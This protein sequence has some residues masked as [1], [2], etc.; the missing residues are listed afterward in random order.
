MSGWIAVDLDGTLAEYHGWV[1]EEHIGAP[2]APMVERVKEWL[3]AGREVRVFTARV[4]GEE[5]QRIKSFI[6]AWCLEYVGVILPVTNKKDYGMIELWDDRCIQVIPNKGLPLGDTGRFPEGHLNEHDE[7]E[8]NIAIAHIGPNV[9]LRFGKPV[10]WIGVPARQARQMAALPTPACRTIRGD[11]SR[12]MTNQTEALRLILGEALALGA[13]MDAENDFLQR[14]G[15]IPL[16]REASTGVDSWTTL[17][18]GLDGV[19]SR[20][21][22]LKIAGYPAC[23]NCEYWDGGGEIAARTATIGDCLNR[24]APRFTTE[25]TFSC[26]QFTPD[27]TMPPGVA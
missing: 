21:D 25:P 12:P 14:A 9:I 5:A 15:W 23:R 20:E 2:V 10:A 26:P 18:R 24:L 19:V 7:G 4:A 27:S 3:A 16:G 13:V 6:E 22:A 1:S 17:E 11:R 8:L